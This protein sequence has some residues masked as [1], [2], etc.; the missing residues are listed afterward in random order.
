M[1]KQPVGVAYRERDAQRLVRGSDQ[2]AATDERSQQPTGPA[3]AQPAQAQDLAPV[4]LCEQT[5][6]SCRGA[7]R[8][9]RRPARCLVSGELAD[10][11]ASKSGVSRA[12]SNR[13]WSRLAARENG[14]E[15][16]QSSV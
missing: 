7:A 9:S 10:A 12:R 5:A 13:I 6:R 16:R 14:E 15:F 2:Q 8:S 11:Q 1:R 4:H 3:F